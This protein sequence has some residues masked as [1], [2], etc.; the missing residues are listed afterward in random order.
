[1]EEFRKYL[2]N[3]VE[4]NDTM[5]SKSVDEMKDEEIQKEAKDALKDEILNIIT[6][7]NTDYF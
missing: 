1:M 4:G 3:A 7:D 5:L 2:V 6:C